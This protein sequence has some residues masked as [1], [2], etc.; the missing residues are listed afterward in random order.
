MTNSSAFAGASEA[1]L[2]PAQQS[3]RQVLPQQILSYL[4]FSLFFPVGVM[5]AGV[6]LFYAS[7]LISGD[8]AAKWQRVRGSPLLLPVL[9][10]TAF[11]IASALGQDRPA[12]FSKEFWPGFWHYQTYLF[13]LPF[14]AVGAGPW[15]RRAIQVFFAGALMAASLFV[16]NYFHLLPANTL[17]R[18]YVVY[19]GNKSILLGILL[20]IAAG[21]MLHELRLRQDRRLLRMVVLLYVVAALVL[22]AKTRTASLLFVLL[23]ALMLMRNF[24]WS[25]RSLVLPLVLLAALAGGWKY[26]LGLPPPATCEVRLVQAPPWEIFKLR[27]LCTIHQL[28]DFS[29]G[30]KVNEDGMRLEIYQITGQIIAEKPWSGH[31][32]ASW[33]ALYQ[34]RAQGLSSAGMTTPHNDYLLYLSEL[35]VFGLLLLLVIW[36]AQFLAA[37]RMARSQDVA[38]NEKAMLLAMLTLAMMV[39]GMFNAIL[40]D[41]VFGMA[42]MI[43]LAIPLAGVETKNK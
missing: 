26:A 41:G 7:L 1:G 3:W 4:P 11:C 16:L 12:T 32:I 24:S 43:L 40:R 21:W 19:E 39:G 38:L 35:G 34:Q 17:F 10:L 30:R 20:A 2:S 36:C 5:Y 6:I 25:W 31:G 42:F 29:E 27:T 15:Q 28:R 13:L 23:C 33:M 37:R 18:S 22:L 9:T 8:Y 14:L